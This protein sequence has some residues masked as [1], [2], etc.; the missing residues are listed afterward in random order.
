MAPPDIMQPLVKRDGVVYGVD[1]RRMDRTSPFISRSLSVNIPRV[2][3]IIL[4]ELP[5][6]YLSNSLGG[7]GS[8]SRS[9]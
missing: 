5:V 1:M 8:V 4:G 7:A 3:A 6:A 2:A 9:S